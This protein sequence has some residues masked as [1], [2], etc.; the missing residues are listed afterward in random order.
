MH[1]SRPSIWEERSSR[2]FGVSRYLAAR[3]RIS[4]IAATARLR[5]SARETIA[6]SAKAEGEEDEEDV[7]EHP[8]VLRRGD[9]I[10]CGGSAPIAVAAIAQLLLLL[11]LLHGIFFFS[12]LFA[13][14]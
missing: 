1:T 6:V 4:S 13:T 3:F 14:A 2:A 5:F 9:N 7:D 8:T 12:A 10:G 11:L